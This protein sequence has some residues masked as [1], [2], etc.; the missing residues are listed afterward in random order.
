[1][2]EETGESQH[3]NVMPLYSGNSPISPSS[4]T[5]FSPA[6]KG[7]LRHSISQDSVSS[8]EVVTKRRRVEENRRVRFSEEVVTIVPPELDLDA[9]DSEEESGGEEDSV[10]E[11]CEVEQAAVE[12]VAPARRP[13][14][15]AWIRALKRRNMGRKHR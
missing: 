4:S 6:P 13:A 9:S 10:I 1:M 12:E 3:D 5:P 2:M 7:V 15:P 8:M 14:L 11:E